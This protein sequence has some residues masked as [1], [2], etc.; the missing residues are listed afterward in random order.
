M[1]P[2]LQLA[3]E[4]GR[5]LVSHASEE[6]KADDVARGLL[7]T[8]EELDESFARRL[9]PYLG[10]VGPAAIARADAAPTHVTR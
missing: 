10:L 1:R 3:F 6:A 2:F 7:A 8:V 5:E 4:E 9:G